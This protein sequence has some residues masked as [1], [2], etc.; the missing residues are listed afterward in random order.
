MKTKKIIKALKVLKNYCDNK[1][2][3]NC[4]LSNKNKDCPV[5]RIPLDWEISLIEKKLKDIERI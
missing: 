4:I 3:E 5:N 1:T 2:C